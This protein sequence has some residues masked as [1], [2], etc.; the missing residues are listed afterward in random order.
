MTPIAHDVGD[1]KPIIK[2]DSKRVTSALA[3]GLEDI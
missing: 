3:H 1:N 2:V